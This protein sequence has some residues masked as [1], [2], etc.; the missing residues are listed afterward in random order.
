MLRPIPKSLMPSTAAVRVPMDGEGGG[1][2]AEEPQ[3]IE[4]VRYESASAAKRSSYVF[5]DGSTGVVYIDA[6]NSIGAFEVP[7][8][9]LVSIDGAPE[10][11]V[12]KCAP[13]ADYAGHVHHWEVEVR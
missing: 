1:E 2:N 7:V 9:S 12:V 4:R 11:C 8:G 13:F 10:V 6:A 3:M 5:A